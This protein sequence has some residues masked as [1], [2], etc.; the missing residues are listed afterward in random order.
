MEKKLLKHIQNFNLFNNQRKAWLVLSAFVVSAVAFIIV[1]RN[2]INLKMMWLLASGGCLTSVV[3]WYWTMR[4]IRQ[5]I[6][7]RKEES[8]ILHEVIVAIK[9][10][11]EDVK[12][13]PK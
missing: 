7:H 12:K 5:L 3:W 6:D 2:Q 8:K 10:I 13:L 1:D 9:E 11:K 4:I